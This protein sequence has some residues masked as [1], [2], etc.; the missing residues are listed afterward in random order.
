MLRLKMD[1]RR[2]LFDCINQHGIDQPDDW[3]GCL[4]RGERGW[5]VTL[6]LNFTQETV[7]QQAMPITLIQRLLQMC[8]RCQYRFEL[9][10]ATQRMPQRI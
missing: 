6:L 3:P 7:Q 2:A 4:L 5:R 8:F 1:I 9:Y 10:A